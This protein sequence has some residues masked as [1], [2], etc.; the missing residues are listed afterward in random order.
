MRK[1]SYAKRQADAKRKAE[2][3]SKA[4]SDVVGAIDRLWKL[5]IAPGNSF[6]E[7]ER[8]AIA[9]ARH[10]LN[11]VQGGWINFRKVRL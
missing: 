11:G 9:D 6:T 3:K 5:S 7:Q 8:Q 2:A 4:V 10:T 1:M